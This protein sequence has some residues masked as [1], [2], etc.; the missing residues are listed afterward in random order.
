MKRILSIGLMLVLACTAAVAAPK[1]NIKI[2]GSTTVLPLSQLWAEKYMEKHSNVSI[3][4]S[5]GGTGQGLSSLINGTCTIANASRVAKSKEIQ[6]ARERNSQ[7][8]SHKVARDGLAI[9]VNPSNNVKNLTIKQLAEI[10]SGKVK[11]WNEV[12]GKSNKEIVLVGRDSSSGTYGFFQD[13]VLGGKA[14]A[15]DMMSIPTS[16]Q[17]CQ[18]VSQSADAIGYVGMAYADEFDNKGKVRVLSLSKKSGQPGMKPTEA[19]VMSGEYP[20]FRFL[21]M[22]TLGSPSGATADFIKF[23]LSSEGQSLVK[24]AGYLPVK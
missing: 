17:I 12:G 11:V 15:K 21:F 22:Y 10:F 4:V 8:V 24:T 13:E 23:S 2:A 19:T 16:Q 5:G 6:S 9:I 3:S 14:Y 20:L 1:G 18:I 7:I